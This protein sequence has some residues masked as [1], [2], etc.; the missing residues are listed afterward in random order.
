MWFSNVKNFTV[1]ALVAW[2]LLLLHMRLP[3]WDNNKTIWVS[4]I[5]VEPKDPWVLNNAAHYLQNGRTVFLLLDLVNLDV[6]EWLPISERAPYII[7][8]NGL[9]NI[10][11]QNNM[12]ESANLVSEMLN[13]METNR[14]QLSV[15]FVAQ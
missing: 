2:Y 4:A 15:T 6:P 11:R 7:G 10:Y 3:E 1:V 8:Y 9:I 13:L 14:K 12:I 5:R